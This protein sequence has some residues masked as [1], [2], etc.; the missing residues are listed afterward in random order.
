MRK[1]FIYV[2]WAVLLLA[3]AAVAAVF[4]AI[5]EGKIGYVPPVEE[6][7]NPNLKFA[8]QIISEDGQLL[9]TWSLSKENRVYVGYEDLSP[10]LVHALVAT[11]DVRFS[12]HSGIDARA[13]MRALIKRGIFMQKNAGGGSTITQ[14]LAKQ[15]YSPVADNVMERLLQKPIE[16]SLIHISEP[17]RPY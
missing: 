16:L 9:G 5:S 15:F 12:E 7:E 8:T 1:T 17:T 14:Q 6:L 4:A 2:L 10:H 3:I 13:F 11:E